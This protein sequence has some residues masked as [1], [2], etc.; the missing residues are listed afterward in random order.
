[1]EIKK[2]DQNA[3]YNQIKYFTYDDKKQELDLNLCNDIET[4][5]HYNLKEDSNIDILAVDGFKKKGIDIFNIKDEFF[6]NICTSFS[7]SDNDMILE[8][9]IIGV[10]KCY[11]LVFKLNNKLNN[12]GFLIFSVLIF[13]YFIF[14]FYFIIKGMKSVSN[15]VFN[16]MVKYGYLN[17]GKKGNFEIIINKQPK[18]I[19]ATT[20]SQKS[21][22]KVKCKKNRKINM[23]KVTKNYNIIYLF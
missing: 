17:K 21:K 12:L 13:F 7:D 11:N 22:R 6:N 18:K 8:D 5:I 16:E 14:F 23:V 2:D 3:L 4:Q 9:R 19:E 15:F 1:M 20:S 10:I